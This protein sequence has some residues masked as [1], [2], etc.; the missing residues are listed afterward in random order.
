MSEGGTEPVFMRGTFALAYGTV[1]RFEAAM[2]EIVPAMAEQGWRLIGAFRNV[3][4][5]LLEVTHLW[6]LPDQASLSEAPARAFGA[7]PELLG[8]VGELSD[9]LRG[10]RLEL[11]A[12]LSYDPSR[13]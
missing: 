5:D 4:G 9:I 10:E 8:R 6:Q 7:H 3:T 12:P 2:A 1:E 11:L 13:A